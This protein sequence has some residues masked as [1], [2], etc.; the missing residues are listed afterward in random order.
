MTAMTVMPREANEWTV[1]DLDQLPDDGLR[2]ELL[3]GT[4]LVSP[5]PTRRHQRAAVNL[6]AFLHRAC[7]A[8]MEVS[9]APLDWRPDDRTSLQPDILVLNNRD[10]NADVADS[11]ILA[12]EVISPSSRRKDSIYKRS[13][14]EDSGVAHYWIVDPAAPS[15]LALEL[16]DGQYVTAGEATGDQPLTLDQPFPIT[17]VPSALIA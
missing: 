5:A 9:A 3:D 10:L 13:K 15:I 4:L 14:Y 6:G 2:Y 8:H 11:M 17:I 7:P 1:R 12:V 16:R